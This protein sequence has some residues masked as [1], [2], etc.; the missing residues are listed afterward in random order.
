MP[1]QAD[2]DM[3]AAG[4]PERIALSHRPRETPLPT[5]AR[6]LA[7]GPVAAAPHMLGCTL[8][9]T[10][11]V[12]LRIVEVE[13][14]GEQAGMGDPASHAFRG[15][16]ASNA[17]MF[18]PA[19]TCYVYRSYGIH[20]CLNIVCGDVGQGAGVLVRAAEVTA[21]EGIV[22]ARRAQRLPLASGPGNVG[23]VLAV[24]LNDNGVDLFAARSWLRLEPRP[25]GT[26]V[27]VLTGPRVGI[28]KANDRPWRFWDADSPAVTRFRSRRPRSGK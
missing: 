22:R 26:T 27:R 17:A 23:A 20:L 18:G 24:S 15:P 3:G 14:Y 5:W 21:G 11:G 9:S 13:A 19:G 8:A 12:A 6:V 2:R 1:S 10:D 25:A 16:T 4:P 7:E 28:S